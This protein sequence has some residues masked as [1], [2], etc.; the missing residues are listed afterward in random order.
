MASSIL[1]P[2]IL[3]DLLTTIPDRAMTAIPVVPPPMST[4]MFPEGL[5]TSIPDPMAA[6]IVS[7]I[8]Y[9]FLAP[10]ASADS[11]TALFSTSVISS[12]TDIITLGRTK[13]L[14]LPLDF[15]MKYS[16][17]LWAASKSAITPSRSG[18]MALI[19]PGV[20]PTISL[21]CLPT[22]MSFDLC[23]GISCTA[24]TD[25]SLDTIPWPFEYTRVFAVPRSIARSFEKYFRSLSSIISY[26]YLFFSVKTGTKPKMLAVCIYKTDE[27]TT[28]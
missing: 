12:G 17:I 21:A 22:A 8:R 9:T 5:S 11:L 18:L 28:K 19:E 3:I 14:L 15:F 10:A 20:L 2:P 16:I 25:G 23:P 1:S 26:N 4:T 24:T 6:H 13:L 7:S 27:S